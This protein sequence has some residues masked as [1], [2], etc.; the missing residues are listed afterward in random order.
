MRR[1]LLL[2]ILCFCLKTHAQTANAGADK[3]VY[4]TQGNSVT[5]GGSSS[6]TSYLWTKIYDIQPVQAGYPT[7]P[8]TINSPTSATTTITGLI[9]GNWYY[10]LAVTTGSTTKKDT[11]VV[12]VDYDAPPAG[13]IYL[14]GIPMTEKKF[15]DST[16]SRWDITH[17]IEGQ[18]TTSEGL[19]FYNRGRL[20][21]MMIDNSR[22]KF[23]STVEDG[24]PWNGNSY[25][26]S[27]LHYQGSSW[28]LDTAKTYVFE[29]KGYFANDFSTIAN[30]SDAVVIMQIHGNDP[31]SPPFSF[32]VNNTKG[33]VF[34]QSSQGSNGSDERPIIVPNL[35]DLV[36][37][38]HTI[39]MTVREGAGYPGQDGFVKVEIDGVQKYLRNTG[40]IGSTL[41]GDY[42]KIA[43][44]YDYGN[45]LVSAS[46]HTRGRAFSLVTEA[47]NVYQISTT[48]QPPV[49]NAGNN[50]AIT[51]PANTINLSGSG[52]DPDGSISSYN[53]TKLSGP[54]AGTIT[55]PNTSA[56]TVTGL[57]QGVYQFQLKVTDNKGATGTSTMQVTVNAASN[58]P[59]A[60]NARIGSG[61]NFTCKFCNPFGKWQ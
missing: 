21:D 37:K 52:T 8:A 44:V 16:N 22:G 20:P 36:L 25:T 42:P 13:A 17:D 30:N 33:L 12:R 6:G 2:P 34:Y 19:I 58:Q 55:N 28:P 4:L 56:T 48:N 31:Y 7:D 32:V 23:Y 26:R 29:W 5:V 45:A 11:V 51:L 47:F 49:A 10:Q 14:R 60:A 1:V 61:N 9:Q 41:M 18:V 50:Q 53:W 57:V 3:T 24:Y 35:S 40:K 43:T 46:N 54:S 27:E 15:A 59:P 39:R 38:T